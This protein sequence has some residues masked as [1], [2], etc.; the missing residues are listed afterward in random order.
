[1]FVRLQAII[2]MLS[3]VLPD[4]NYTPI[5]HARVA[6]LRRVSAYS[7]VVFVLANVQ[8]ANRIVDESVKKSFIVQILPAI[9]R[10]GQVE[11]EAGIV[12]YLTLSTNQTNAQN[13]RLT[14]AF[15]VTP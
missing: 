12:L 15:L 7:D 9:D 5:P 2:T 10:A 6:A 4:F 8:N 13:V 14:A 3:L 11:E 1:M